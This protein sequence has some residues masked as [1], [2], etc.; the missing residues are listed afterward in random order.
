MR[1][2]GTKTDNPV[3]IPSTSAIQIATLPASTDSSKNT[4]TTPEIQPT[5][6]GIST[7]DAITAS[8]SLNKATNVSTPTDIPVEVVS[9]PTIQPTTD[10][11]TFFDDFQNHRPIR[12][13]ELLVSSDDNFVA[14]ELE[15]GRLHVI[16]KSRDYVKPFYQTNVVF[17]NFDTL[18]EIS[19]TDGKPGVLAIDFRLAEDEWYTFLVGISG[20]KT[21]YFYMTSSGNHL[22]IREEGKDTASDKRILANDVSRIRIKCIGNECSFFINDNLV[23]RFPGSNSFIKTGDKKEAFTGYNVVKGIVRLSAK[24]DFAFDLNKVEI[25]EQ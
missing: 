13:Q 3:N 10:K 4:N 22:E 16:S 20:N 21:G 24:G 23:R 2:N 11:Q 17:D 5:D 19:N 25:H 15:G 1:N 18:I 14:T 9:A 8:P 12:S 7:E 6:A